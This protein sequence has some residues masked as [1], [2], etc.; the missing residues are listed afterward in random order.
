MGISELGFPARVLLDTHAWIWMATGETSRLFQ[1]AAEAIERASGEQRLLVSAASAWEIALKQRR[2]DLKV[3]T[4][5]Q[6]WIAAQRNSPGIRFVP[7]TAGLL[8]EAVELPR[9]IRQR[10]GREHR[11]PC[12]R[13]IVATARRQRAILVTCDPE[14]I[15]CGRAGHLRVYDARP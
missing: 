1:G 7:L 4:D 15:G 3:S 11:D 12:D 2:G 9:W 5:L 10:D 14:I 8:V 13:F 6:G